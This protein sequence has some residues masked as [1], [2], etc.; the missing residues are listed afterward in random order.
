MSSR[1]KERDE[2][3]L[4]VQLARC[5]FSGILRV[6]FFSFYVFCYVVQIFTKHDLFDLFSLNERVSFTIL[7]SLIF[8]LPQL[9]NFLYYTCVTLEKN[10][11]FF[12]YNLQMFDSSSDF[13][14]SRK[15]YFCQFWFFNEIYEKKYCSNLG[16]K[17]DNKYLYFDISFRYRANFKMNL[18]YINI[19]H[20]EL[21]S[22]R[23]TVY[24][25]VTSCLKW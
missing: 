21:V 5:K 10:I 18:M 16:K 23:V 11:C 25:G 13:I 14:R 17:I 12:K 24:G 8:Y 15:L 6:F 22:N 2:R 3:L 4:M 7:H 19:P 1:I 20:I 9:L